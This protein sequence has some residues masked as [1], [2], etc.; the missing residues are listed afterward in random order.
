MDGEQRRDGLGAP[1][2]GPARPGRDGAAAARP[3]DQRHRDVP[4]PD[5]STS[6]SARRSCRC[7][8]LS[9]LAA[10]GRR[11]LDRRGGLLARDPARRGG[12]LDRVADLRDRHQRGR[13]R[14]ARGSASSRS[15][16]C[17]S[18]RRT[19]SAP[20]ARARSP[21]TTS[22]ATTARASPRSLVDN[23]VF[24]QHNLASDA[25]FNEF[26]VITL[27]QRDDLLRPAAAGARAPALLRE[28]GDVR[29]P[30]ARPEGDDPV[31]A[32]TRT[33]YEELDAA[34]KAL[35]GRLAMTLD[36]LRVI[37]IGASWG[38]L[39]A[40]GTL[41]D[42]HPGRARRSRSSSRSTA[43]P[44]RTAALLES[45]LQ[46]HIARPVSEPDDKEPI[47]PRHVYVAPAGLP[48]ARRRTAASRSRSTRASSTRGRRSTCCS[49]RSP[50]PTASARSG[51]C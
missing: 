15:T 16:R 49:S 32:R 48:P 41:L 45:L 37:A 50:R 9:V 5:A 28:P 3:L 29:R 51:S 14:A 24:A 21:S 46:R 20:A 11:L 12:P 10:L 42:G 35:P 43:A 33:R 38:G 23:V 36:R 6:R 4:R 25:A 39:Q 47:E 44:S 8:G 1:G 30:R 34:E 17:R 31:L 7:C 18:T 19:T 2:A 27:P 22:R 40:V 13:A 26:H